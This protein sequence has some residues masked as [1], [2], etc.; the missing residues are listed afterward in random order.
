MRFEFDAVVG[1]FALATGL[2]VSIA[3]LRGGTSID[4]PLA[5]SE[6]LIETRND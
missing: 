1:C 4:S 5:R 2:A 6:I 3:K